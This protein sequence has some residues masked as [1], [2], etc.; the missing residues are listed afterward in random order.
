[1]KM[2]KYYIL[3]FILL[4]PNLALAQIKPA[5][6]MGR[7]SVWSMFSDLSGFLYLILGGIGALSIIGFIVAGI[8]YMAAG[9]D[10]ERVGRAGGI[11]GFALVGLLIAILGIIIINIAGN[12]FSQQ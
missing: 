5:P 6:E 1:M 8:D 10:E 9:G 11:F 4:I 7:P 12:T 3:N 2:K